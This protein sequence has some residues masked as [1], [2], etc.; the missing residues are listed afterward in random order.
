MNWSSEKRYAFVIEYFVHKA[1]YACSLSKTQLPVLG[2]RI[3]DFP[4]QLLYTSE[5]NKL[6]FNYGKRSIFSI[7]PSYFFKSLYESPLYVMLADARLT[8]IR[9]LGDAAA[10]ISCF[11]KDNDYLRLAKHGRVVRR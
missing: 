5:A 11:A 7:R 6:S 2:I 8:K 3:L 10:D 9:L 1:S 4:T